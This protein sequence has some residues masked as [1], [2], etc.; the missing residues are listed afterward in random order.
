M[1]GWGRGGEGG[2]GCGLGES[3]GM[4]TNVCTVSVF[5]SDSSYNHQI[6]TVFRA[7]EWKHQIL[8]VACVLRAVVVVVAVAV[9]SAYI[10]Y[11]IMCIYVFLREK[12]YVG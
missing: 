10:G 4:S 1:W 5:F 12:A 9:V 11:M 8:N 3:V 7:N 2:G 6:L